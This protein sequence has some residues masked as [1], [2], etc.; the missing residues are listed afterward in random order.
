VLILY[1]GPSVKGQGTP[2]SGAGTLHSQGLR[3]SGLW[4]R[5]GGLVLVLK[6]SMPAEP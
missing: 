6:R 1:G 5:H 4:N 3:D 2:R